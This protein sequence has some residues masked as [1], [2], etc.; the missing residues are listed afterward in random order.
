M[1][2]VTRFGEVAIDHFFEFGEQIL[3]GVDQNRDSMRDEDLE[4]SE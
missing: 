2:S 1:T 4:E 3:E